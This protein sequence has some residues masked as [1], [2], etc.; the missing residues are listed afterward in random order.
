MIDL[1]LYTYVLLPLLIFAARV[2]DVSLDTLRIIFISRGMKYIAPVIGFFEIIIWI[3]AIGLV[4]MEGAPLTT[5]IAYA[6]GFA[7]GTYVGIIIEEKMAMGYTVIRIITQH[8]SPRLIESLKSSGFRTTTVD[9]IG[10]FGMVSIIFTVVKRKNIPRVLKKINEH[11][12]SAFYTIEDVRSARGVF[13][14][15]DILPRKAWGRFSR[16]GK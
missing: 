9:A 7:T 11:N 12:P 1:E 13:D 14:G 16:V 10:Q 4:L 15:S 3:N 6:L 2:T 5:T 8:G